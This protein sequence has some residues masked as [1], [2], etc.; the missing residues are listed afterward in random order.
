MET[1]KIVILMIKMTLLMHT[2][3]MAIEMTLYWSLLLLLL[4][5][6]MT[7]KTLP[8]S[9]LVVYYFIFLTVL[10]VGPL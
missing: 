8:F 6:I 10:R 7:T 9:L 3:T 1:M 4:L 5:M 2:V